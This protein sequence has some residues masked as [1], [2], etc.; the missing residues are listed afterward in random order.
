MNQGCQMSIYPTGYTSSKSPYPS[1]PA[2]T[3]WSHT[4]AHKA[5][6]PHPTSSDHLRLQKD[7]LLAWLQGDQMSW[8][9]ITQ[10]LEK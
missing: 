3:T 6:L 8:N 7:K 1:L 10:F 4:E 9:K 2:Q 5:S